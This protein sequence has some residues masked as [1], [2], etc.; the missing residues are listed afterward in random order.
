MKFLATLLFLCLAVPRPAD[1]LV[2]T[3]SQA[4]EVRFDFSVVDFD[5]PGGTGFYGG[6]PWELLAIDHLSL[7]QVAVGELV[8]FGPDDFFNSFFAG[9]FIQGFGVAFFEGTEYHPVERGFRFIY[10]E[11]LPATEVPEFGSS[12]LLTLLGLIGICV[13]RHIGY[14]APATERL[15]AAARC[16]NA[17]EKDHAA[18]AGDTRV[19]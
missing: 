3:I 6:G 13:A 2:V 15:R 19:T 9:F 7:D 8:V 18:N 17:P 5:V 12:A 10:G 16:Q 1:A 14:L 4:D 11:P